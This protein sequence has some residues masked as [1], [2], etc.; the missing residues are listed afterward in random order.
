MVKKK[1][2]LS[3]LDALLVQYH[4]GPAF[5]SQWAEPSG[6][7]VFSLDPVA[8]DTVGWRLVEQLRS[9]KGLPALQEEGREP[10]YLRTAERMGL[11]RA[12]VKDIQ[13]IEDEV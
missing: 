3:I 2:R 6:R 4:R 10:A 11:G 12:G 9:N 1:H 13:I 7:L 8:A 5:H